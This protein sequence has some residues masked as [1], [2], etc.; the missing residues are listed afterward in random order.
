MGLVCWFACVGEAMNPFDYIDFEYWFGWAVDDGGTTAFLQSVEASHFW[1]M[2]YGRAGMSWPDWNDYVVFAEGKARALIDAG[3]NE[4][5]QAVISYWADMQDY[6][7]NV[8]PR[9]AAAAGAGVE[10]ATSMGGGTTEKKDFP[11]WLLAG[12]AALLLWRK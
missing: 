12:G 6:L 1:N 3:Q 4:S 5:N 10:A 2:E 11:W 8:S 9:G 7:S